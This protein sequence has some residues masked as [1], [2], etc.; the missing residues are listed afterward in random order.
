MYG[1]K[2]NIRLQCHSGL[3]CSSH[4]LGE[5]ELCGMKFRHLQIPS[6]MLRTEEIV[7]R[8]SCMCCSSVYLWYHT[9]TQSLP[10]T[11]LEGPELPVVVALVI[12][13]ALSSTTFSDLHSEL[14]TSLAENLLEVL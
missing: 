1:T 11:G 3:F 2:W 9:A 14:Q 12:T 4:H 7:S 13:K 5:A 10:A 8:L 6:K